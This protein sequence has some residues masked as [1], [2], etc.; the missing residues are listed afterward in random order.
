MSTV[1]NYVNAA[2]TVASSLYN[3]TFNTIV[4]AGSLGALIGSRY[5]KPAT[6]AVQSA[7]IGLFWNYA[8]P[9]TFG[10]IFF[11]KD[12]SSA[13]NML[14]AGLSILTSLSIPYLYN[15]LVAF[16]PAETRCIGRLR[17]EVAE[18][19]STWNE[20]S[21]IFAIAMSCVIGSRIASVYNEFQRRTWGLITTIAFLH[22]ITFIP[23]RR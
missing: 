18:L 17:K 1:P 12:S 13:A 15:R 19:P 16:I 3:M 14:G 4:L 2:N 22:G 8:V 6:Y 21:G 23:E 9:H 5:N 11:H 20:I 7:L 10:K